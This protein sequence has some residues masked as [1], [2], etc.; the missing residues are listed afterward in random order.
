MGEKIEIEAI[1]KYYDRWGARQDSQAYYESPIFN[2]I[3]ET[4]PVHAGASIFELGCGT[5]MFAHALMTRFAQQNIHY[6]ATDLS[7]NMVKLARQRLAPWQKRITIRHSDAQP[8]IPAET[9]SLSHVVSTYVLDILT[10]RQIRAFLSDSHR[11]LEHGGFLIVA[12][13]S[14]GFN[15]RTR[16]RM[17]FWQWQYDNNPLRVGGCRPMHLQPLLSTQAWKLNQHHRFASRG[18]SSELLIVTKI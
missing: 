13:I 9:D 17:R 8:V 3:L 4:V 16:L 18:V 5:G 6:T 15:L 12:G 10:E 11:V 2:H 14:P 7:L 1:A